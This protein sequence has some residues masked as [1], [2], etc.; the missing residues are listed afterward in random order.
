MRYNHDMPISTLEIL[1]LGPPVGVSTRDMP[2]LFVHDAWHGAWCWAEQF[3]PYFAARGW[4]VAALSL[5]GHGASAP[6]PVS[7]AGYLVDVQAVLR[8]L[9]GRAVLIGHGVGGYLVQLLL[10]ERN[11][12]GAV[13][14]ASVPQRGLSWSWWRKTQRAARAPSSWYLWQSPQEWTAECCRALLFR[15]MENSV[16]YQQ[17]L[18]REP[19]STWVELFAGAKA[20]PGAVNTPM[21]VLAA[22]RDR[23]VSPAQMYGLAHAYRADL[24]V[25]PGA[26]HDLMLE[27]GWEVG[28]EAILSWL[29]RRFG[30]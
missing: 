2:V 27:P 7:L 8:E 13:L 14:L 17:R 30:A 16:R 24:F 6:A 25:V 23:M 28:A 29:D 5:R 9:G 1:R 20:R 11:L 4:P 10:T 19:F 18:D 15:E 12:P 21:L 22:E 3:L 26:A